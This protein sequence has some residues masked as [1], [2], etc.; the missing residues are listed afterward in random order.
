MGNILRSPLWENPIANPTIEDTTYRLI[1]SGGGKFQDYV[2]L[3][4]ILDKTLVNKVREGHA[5][6]IVH[7]D[8]KYKFRACADSMAGYYARS[9]GYI[10][11]P[12]PA[13]WD[14]FGKRAGHM[15]NYEMSLYGHALVAFWNKK[16]P[17]TKSMI[18]LA[19]RR[20]LPVR[21]IHVR[22]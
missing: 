20:G 2:L 8:Q 4:D 11:T 7:G 5:I 6:E 21:V 9:K 18:T 17:G 16:S 12:V 13:P 3:S 14:K 1:V 22:Y 10:E 15:R 19:E